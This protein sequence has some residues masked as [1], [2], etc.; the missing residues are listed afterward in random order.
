MPGVAMVMGASAGATVPA[1]R[2]PACDGRETFLQATVTSHGMSDGGRRTARPRTVAVLGGGVGGLS[3]AHELAERGFE[4]T[5]Y[6][7]RRDCG[8]KARSQPVAG[9]GTEGRRDLPG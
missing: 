8:G 9:T 6:E 4:V 7:A 3:A 5:V 2:R 1:R